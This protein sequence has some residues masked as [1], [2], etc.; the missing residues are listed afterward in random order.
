MSD[1]KSNEKKKRPNYSARGKQF[2]RDVANALAHLFPNAQRM[3]E[4]QA[5]KVVGVD[6][7][8][9]GEFAF[10]CK[11]NASYCPISKITE[12]RVRDKTP[13][14]ITKGNN[15]PAMAVLPFQDFIGLLERIP[16]VKQDDEIIVEKE[17]ISTTAKA[18][19]IV[20]DEDPE[21]NVYD[22]Q[23]YSSP[24]KGE[25]HKDPDE[26]RKDLQAFTGLKTSFVEGIPADRIR[27]TYKDKKDGIRCTAFFS[28][29]WTRSSGP[30]RA[31]V[32]INEW[33]DQYDADPVELAVRAP[34]TIQDMP[35]YLTEPE[36]V[37]EGAVIE[38][39]PQP[40]TPTY[41]FL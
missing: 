33:C 22:G 23:V 12:I 13:V 17:A 9:T 15:V 26:A 8:N 24:K 7:E 20:H 14:L 11:R 37:D 27:L 19:A 38:E 30:A 36:T 28:N 41:S 31:M 39:A 10:Q 34:D 1:E 6:L 16:G 35:S 29:E 5:S 32:S 40:A 3:L 2:E 25:P 4:Y 18:I 21:E